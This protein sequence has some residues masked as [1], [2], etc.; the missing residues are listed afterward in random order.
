MLVVKMN[1]G[2]PRA[3]FAR[4]VFDFGFSGNL[5][6]AISTKPSDSPSGTS[7]RSII[8]PMQQLSRCRRAPPAHPQ[9]VPRETTLEVRSSGSHC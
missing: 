5:N 8:D 4:G 2:A 3:G 6:R 1:L 9:D 7:T